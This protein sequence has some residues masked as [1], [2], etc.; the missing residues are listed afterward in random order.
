MPTIE[1]VRQKG[2]AHILILILLLAGLAA[3]VY[4]VSSGNPLKL[5]SK[6]SETKTQSKIINDLTSQLLQK[7][8]E[9]NNLTKDGKVSVQVQQETIDNLTALAIRRKEELLKEIESNPQAF[10]N[11]AKLADQKD[12][13]PKEVKSYLEEKL[14]LQGELQIF[15]NDNF[16]EKVGKYDYVLKPLNSKYYNLYF[17]Q[18]TPKLLSGSKIVASGVALDQKMA[19][20]DGQEKFLQVIQAANSIVT[21]GEL[22]LLIILINFPDN[23]TQP[24]T[25]EAVKKLVFD[26]RYSVNNYYNEA[27]FGKL[28]LSGDVIGWFTLASSSSP[29]QYRH[30]ADEADSK[31]TAAGVDIR[32]Y[33]RVVYVFPGTNCAFRGVAGIGGTR[34]WIFGLGD[35][36]TYA[37]ELGHTLGLDHANALTCDL[38]QIGRNSECTPWEYGDRFD[39]MGFGGPYHFNVAHKLALGWIDQRNIQTVT[40]SG[41][42]TINYPVEVQPSSVG[43][44][45]L[46]IPKSKNKYEHFANIEFYYLEF[47]K[48]IGFDL[49]TDQRTDTITALTKG[50]RIIIWGDG[51]PFRFPTYIIDTSPSEAVQSGKPYKLCCVNLMDVALAD[52][53]VFDDPLNGITVKQLSHTADSVTLQIILNEDVCKSDINK[54]GSVNLTDFSILS[55]CFGKRSTETDEA[56]NSCARADI[57]GDGVID[58]T[59][60]TCLKSQYGQA[61]PEN[62]K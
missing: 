5:F 44:Q 21:T 45:L 6:A 22:K 51:E 50:A 2:F 25:K 26:D 31:A 39:V 35:T 13:F 37:H 47:R 27:S 14:S 28:S 17:V 60:F 52:Q 20:L 58:R 30:W 46:R 24:F 4:L 34:A 43:I 54:D 36:Y 12:T 49:T 61:C 11:D 42:Y 57:N 8:D 7:R 32:K 40:H 15:H 33:Y 38:Q 9:Y 1:S 19:L 55:A 3:G 56:G 23:T 16:D 18:N 10:L 59:D 41:K 53:S 48:S 62:K 29:C